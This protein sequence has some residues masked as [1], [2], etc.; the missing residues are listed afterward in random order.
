MTNTTELPQKSQSNSLSDC[1]IASHSPFFFAEI[2]KTINELGKPRNVETLTGAGLKVGP[3]ING[4]LQTKFYQ[5][6]LNQV[7]ELL[8]RPRVSTPIK[9]KKLESGLN[10]F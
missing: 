5:K 1:G 2:T 6:N 4:F 7:D 3:S 8:V 10:L 9:I